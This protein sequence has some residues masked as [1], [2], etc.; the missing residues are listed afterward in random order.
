MGGHDER[1][2]PF[3]ISFPDAPAARSDGSRAQV[4]VPVMRRCSWSFK[5]RGGY[6]AQH[7]PGLA[8]PARTPPRPLAPDDRRLCLGPRIGGAI[9][10]PGRAPDGSLHHGQAAARETCRGRHCLVL[11]SVAAAERIRGWCTRAAYDSRR[12][13]P[14]AGIQRRERS[15]SA[16][17]R[18][19]A[20]PQ[21]CGAQNEHRLQLRLEWLT[22]STGCPCGNR[23]S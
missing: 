8:R 13:A 5:R 11:Q 17:G 12:N 2:V 9:R 18:A 1:L 22:F 20:A 10:A 4:A 19:A 16:H 3:G 6:G 7:W 14:K 15:R 21:P 23:R